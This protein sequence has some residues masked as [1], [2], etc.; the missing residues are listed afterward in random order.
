MD[1]S[2]L[3]E[4]QWLEED[5][6]DSRDSLERGYVSSHLLAQLENALFLHSL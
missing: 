6:G 5:N 4:A 1:A 3:Q 2:Y